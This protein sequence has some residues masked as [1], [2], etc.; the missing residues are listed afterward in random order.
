MHRGICEICLLEI[1]FRSWYPIYK[2]V[3]VTSSKESG[4]S[5]LVPLVHDILSYIDLCNEI[6]NV[7]FVFVH[8]RSFY[9]I[10][11][12]ATCFCDRL[13]K[14]PCKHQEDHTQYLLAV[15]NIDIPVDVNFWGSS[16]STSSCMIIMSATQL[17]I[18]HPWST[19]WCLSSN[20]FQWLDLREGHQGPVYWQGLNLIPARI[21]GYIPYRG[22][23][24]ITYPFPNF[25]GCTV[26]IWEWISNFIP[27]FPGHAFTYPC[28]D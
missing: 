5:W 7:S 9:F 24:E 13:C 2:S 16:P 1:G 6:L 4:A 27:H 26:E 28:W 11:S 10:L 12:H 15:Y 21:C 3:P 22:G 18:G 8:L 17:I 19:Y 20:K 23:D 25:N 14:A